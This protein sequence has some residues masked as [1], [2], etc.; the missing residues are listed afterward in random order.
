MTHILLTLVSSPFFLGLFYQSFYLEYNESTFFSCSYSHLSGQ[1]H[2]I[3]AFSA[4]LD[5]V[6]LPSLH[7][8]QVTRLEVRNCDFKGWVWARNPFI[9]RGD[10]V[11]DM[12]NI[13]FLPRFRSPHNTS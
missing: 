12:A 6:L 4:R 2:L 11:E 7:Q 5:L 8:H 9:L 13:Q 10:R 1:E 3:G